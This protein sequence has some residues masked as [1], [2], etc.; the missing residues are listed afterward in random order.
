MFLTRKVR[1]GILNAE[2]S[3]VEAVEYYFGEHFGRREFGDIYHVTSPENGFA[4][5]TSAYGE[6]LCVARILFKNGETGITSRYIDFEMS[7]AFSKRRK[8]WAGCV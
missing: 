4:M 2:F 6:P 8:H 5:T 3:D 7:G 1:K